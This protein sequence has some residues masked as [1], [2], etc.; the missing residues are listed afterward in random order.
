MQDQHWRL[1]PSPN[2]SSNSRLF[3]P[4]SLNRILFAI[5]TLIITLIFILIPFFELDWNESRIFL[6]LIIIDVAYLLTLARAQMRFGWPRL[7]P[8]V[9]SMNVIL[10]TLM[11]AFFYRALPSFWL[12]YF[13]LPIIAAL[14]FGSGWAYLSG[15]LSALAYVGVSN[16]FGFIQGG[17]GQY[18]LNAWVL[19]GFA[20][21]TDGI[22]TSVR[23][24]FQTIQS[25]LEASEAELQSTYLG[26][27][28]A[29]AKA[30]DAKDTYTS[31]HSEQMAEL[32]VAVGRMLGMTESE[33]AE[34]KYG[35][36]LHDIGKIGVADTILKKPHALDANEW[37]QMRRHPDI[38]AQI[39]LPMPRLAGVA[40]IV[41]NH[42]ER[43]D[44]TGY[45]NGLAGEGIPL[46]ARILAIVD[47]YSAITDRRDY[48]PARPPAEAVQE[49]QRCAGTHFDPAV[50][51]AFLRVLEQANHK[52]TPP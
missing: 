48:K 8:I 52:R 21:L 6:V 41:A 19:V 9:V 26:T 40:Q 25:R 27:V 38:G 29:L 49:I 2:P 12:F 45:S 37:E 35:A 3:S 47:A 14:L 18:L 11:V 5:A 31:K 22:G 34:L 51:E 43:F 10:I 30:V 20:I 15:A 39:L 7:A 33:M 46:G 28:M 24:Q 32:A 16:I 23:R 50:V 36:I 44:G 17:P 13:N 42:H 4:K 1:L